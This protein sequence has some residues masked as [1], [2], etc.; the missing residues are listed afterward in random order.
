MRGLLLG[1]LYQGGL[2][3]EETC[4]VNLMDFDNRGGGYNW[5]FTVP[6]KR[7][8]S[9]NVIKALRQDKVKSPY[10][11]IIVFTR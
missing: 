5:G 1:D 2:D 9:S 8:Q 3:L 11:R 10:R 7:S 6:L 4:L